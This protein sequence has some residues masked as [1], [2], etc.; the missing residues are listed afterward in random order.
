[1]TER[2]TSPG[3]LEPPNG[4]PPRPSAAAR[5]GEQPPP[6]RERQPRGAVTKA[7]RRVNQSEAAERLIASPEHLKMHDSNVWEIRKHRDHARDGVVEW[8]ELRELASQIK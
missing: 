7:G 1:M 3:V 5:S 2:E 6:P 8:E 4:A